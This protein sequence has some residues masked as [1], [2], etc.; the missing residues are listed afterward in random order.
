MK[1]ESAQS[2]NALS[3]SESANLMANKYTLVNLMDNAERG[4]N[5]ALCRFCF[6]MFGKCLVIQRHQESRSGVAPDS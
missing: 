3:N 4:Q 1:Q 5:N 6:P 2:S